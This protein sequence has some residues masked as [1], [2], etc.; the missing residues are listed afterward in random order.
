MNIKIKHQSD[1]RVLFSVRAAS[2][3]EA[4]VAAAKQ[5]PLALAGA[6]L[7]GADL[8]GL[9]LSEGVFS[10]TDLRGANLRGA[11]L[12]NVSF[13]GANLRGA[14]LRDAVLVCTK[15]YDS[16]PGADLADADLRG[17]QLYG[18]NLEHANLHG[19]KLEGIRLSQVGFV[20]P[21]FHLGP[22]FAE[23]KINWDSRSLIRELLRQAAGDDP[24]KRDAVERIPLRPEPETDAVDWDAWRAADAALKAWVSDT[25]AVFAEP[26]NPPRGRAAARFLWP[27]GDFRGQASKPLLTRAAFSSYEIK[28]RDTGETLCWAEG[29]SFKEALAVASEKARQRLLREQAGFHDAHYSPVT[30]ENADLRGVDLSGVSLDDVD[31]SGADLRGANLRSLILSGGDLSQADLRSADLR[32]ADLR[33]T[34]L[35]GADLAEADLRGTKLTGMKLTDINLRGAK[36]ESGR[37]RGAALLSWLTGG[38]DDA[39]GEIDWNS[40][41]TVSELLRS[42]AGSDRRKQEAAERLPA[43]PRPHDDK[44]DWKAWEKMDAPLKKWVGNTLAASAKGM[45]SLPPNVVARFLSPRKTPRWPHSADSASVKIEVRHFLTGSLLFSA[46]ASSLKAAV[47]EAVEKTLAARTY[48]EEGGI[49]G[50]SYE[51]LDLSGADLRG[52]DLGGADLGF[53]SLDDADLRG[54]NLRGAR[55]SSTSLSGADLE[56]ADLRGTDLTYTSLRDADLTDASFAG[57]RINWRSYALVSELLRQA[58]AGDREKLAVISQIPVRPEPD[59]DEIDWQKWETAIFP[60]QDWTWDTL[61]LFVGAENYSPSWLKK[62]TDGQQD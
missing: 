42:A 48:Y 59:E 56:G 62:R 8:S 25:L 37:L 26:H 9:E 14:D 32:S 7:R 47:T 39:A 57:C 29:P 46:Q 11:K 49:V 24:A 18:V 52:A 61:A 16:S 17:A 58:A 45:N 50:G 51:T 35:N 4:V 43:L 19:A 12:S 6:N 15:F 60:Q 22:D 38:R 55:L 1:D 21:I 20:Y 10:G 34:R 31:L 27:K 33:Y 54:A 5:P 44:I 30:L 40:R 41:L 2:L 3:K 28:R 53:A 23:C 36:M 13:G